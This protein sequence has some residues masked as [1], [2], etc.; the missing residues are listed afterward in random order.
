[1]AD[2]KVSGSIIGV[3]IGTAFLQCQAEATLNMIGNVSEDAP[4][5]V[6]DGTSTSGIPWVTRTVDSKDWNVTVNQSL[7]RDSLAA[8]ND[9]VNLGKIFIDTDLQVANVLFR[10]AEDQEAMDSD[11]I[12]SGP[13][14]LSGFSITAPA[15]GANT[16][17]ATFSG[18]GALTYQ[19]IP[20]TT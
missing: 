8:E 19:F 15:T 5:K 9:G 12:Y 10:T 18:N 4:C 14:I 16:T 17:A 13:A 2:N 1:M 11:M 3:Q 7:L 20:V 6:L